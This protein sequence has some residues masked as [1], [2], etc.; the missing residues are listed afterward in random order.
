MNDRPADSQ[1][2]DIVAR[3]RQGCFSDPCR[4]ME[5]RSG[6]TCAEAADEIERLRATLREIR[7]DIEEAADDIVWMRGG[8]E[9]VHDRITAVLGDQHE[10]P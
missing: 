9:T 2:T 6:C 1:T 5:A 4:M 3:L 10:Q 7:R 8:I